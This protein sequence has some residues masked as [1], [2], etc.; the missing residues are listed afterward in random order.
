[1]TPHVSNFSLAPLL[2]KAICVSR[3]KVAI[4]LTNE[5]RLR[6][7]ALAALRDLAPLRCLERG[8]VARIGEIQEAR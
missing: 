7:I 2:P 8:R 6:A 5:S 4:P 1:M 3:R